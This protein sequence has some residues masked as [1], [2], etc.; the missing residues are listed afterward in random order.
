LAEVAEPT[1]AEI[2]RLQS[3]SESR[4]TVAPP[5]IALISILVLTVN[6]FWLIAFVFPLALT[7]QGIGLNRTATAELFDA[8]RAR[9]QTPELERIT[10]VFA[11]SEPGLGFDRCPAAINLAAIALS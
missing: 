5:L 9:N 11:L 10:P 4:L 2:E 1:D 6:F 8:L 7:I 3:E